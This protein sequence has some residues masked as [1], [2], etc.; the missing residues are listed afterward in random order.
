M[1][2]TQTNLAD[3][4]I[5]PTTPPPCWWY[6]HMQTLLFW[7][8]YCSVLL[9]LFFFFYTHKWHV[10]LQEISNSNLRLGN[11][12]LWH[13]LFFRSKQDETKLMTFFSLSSYSPDSTTMFPFDG[14]KKKRSINAELCPKC[15][16]QPW[17]ASTKHLG[18][19][20]LCCHRRN[21][22]WLQVI[23]R[24]PSSRVPVTAL[25]MISQWKYRHTDIYI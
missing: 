14:K 12:K 24:D 20:E 4:K 23:P 10:S 19:W 1:Y 3:Q 18:R 15:Q 25:S 21:T 5:F 17:K 22:G 13:R 6:S 2:Q 16:N 8:S 11:R 7:Q 9:F